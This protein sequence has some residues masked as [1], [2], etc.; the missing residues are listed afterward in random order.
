MYTHEQRTYSK[1]RTSLLKLMSTLIAVALTAS[2]LPTTTFASAITTDP[3][4]WNVEALTEAKNAERKAR[5]E[6]DVDEKYDLNILLI[7]CSYGSDTITYTVHFLK[8]LYPNLKINIGRLFRGTTPIKD[9]YE[10]SQSGADAYAYIEHYYNGNGGG[11]SRSTLFSLSTSPAYPCNM[12]TALDRA[13][14]DIVILQTTAGYCA[15][16][17]SYTDSTTNENYVSALLNYVD[18]YLKTKNS[19]SS[20]EFAWNMVWPYPSYSKASSF[21]DFE[22]NQLKMY[23]GILH[24]VQ[25]DVVKA[26]SE[27]DYIIP[28]GTA[29]VNA[30][31]NG[32]PD[33]VIYR[34]DIHL[35][36]QTNNMVG[37]G[38]WTTGLTTA[39]ALALQ[40]D[41]IKALDSTYSITSSDKAEKIVSAVG[42][43]STDVTDRTVSDYESLITDASKQAL[44]APFMSISSAARLI[45]QATY[46]FHT[47]ELTSVTEAQ[48]KAKLA[49]KVNAAED[50]CYTG[51][52]VEADDITVYDYDY[53]LSGDQ[54]F[55]FTV[56]Y[57]NGV[58]SE[59]LN[60][61]STSA[62]E[63]TVS[64]DFE[65]G[66]TIPAVSTLNFRFNRP[67]TSDT[68]IPANII[69]KEE[70]K[71]TAN[72]NERIYSDYE[73]KD[74]VYTINF[75]EGDLA[76]NTKYTL[77]FTTDIKTEDDLTLPE[78]QTFTFTTTAS[79]GW[80]INDNF[81][82]YPLNSEIPAISTKIDTNLLPLQYAISNYVHDT[83]LAA[84]V[85]ENGRKA[86]KVSAYYKSDSAP[87]SQFSVGYR[88]DYIPNVTQTKIKKCEV[89]FDFYGDDSAVYGIYTNFFTIARLADGKYY[90]CV[91]NAGFGTNI[92]ETTKTHYYKNK[93]SPLCEISEATSSSSSPHK[94]SFLMY[95]DYKTSSTTRRI[96]DVYLDGKKI[97]KMVDSNGVTASGATYISVPESGIGLSDG[98]Q[99][100][101]G[102][103]DI[104]Y[105]ETSG[106]TMKGNQ[107]FTSWVDATKTGEDAKE[108]NLRIYSFKYGECPSVSSNIE[109]FALDVYC[110][111]EVLLNF[112]I[113]LHA[114]SND[115]ESSITVTATEN[116]SAVDF[117]VDKLDSKTLKLQFR[118]NVY[119]D[120]R[121]D[122]SS[123]LAANSLPLDTFSLT[124]KTEPLGFIHSGSESSFDTEKCELNIKETFQLFNRRTTNG[125][126]YKLI[127]AVYNGD[128]LIYTKVMNA[129]TASSAEVA[130]LTVNE[131]LTSDD[132]T[133][134]DTFTYKAFVF[135][136]LNTLVP[137][138]LNK[139]GAI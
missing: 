57:E 31:G 66:V 71:G 11:V 102:V 61:R 4:N 79:D 134:D 28:N 47:D 75:A 98:W 40:S 70:V 133:S 62:T 114:S 130:E 118:K 94:L 68:A 87:A 92:A 125:I 76:A 46:R 55:S 137:L 60:A 51:V 127:F 110:D 19:S 65:N 123:L 97:T 96:Y 88:T 86:L 104:L 78:E 107:M 6:L 115:Y 41:K 45:E 32:I 56:T 84:I 52:T 33:A 117:T 16:D 95:S 126:N 73:Y 124:F 38:L 109:P 85:S 129:T 83:N 12:Q 77:T 39:C 27:I 48:L 91:R 139:L 103:H 131:A 13:D 58:T 26:V 50:V 24:N 74:G 111:R 36:D 20:P 8:A 22:N 128:K 15:V 113:P 23:N 9:H 43:A 121:I 25:K 53:A 63:L 17:G 49:E 132:F 119:M 69:L 100:T 59:R 116:D 101:A 64:A 90:L 2:L 105:K 138:T 37:A 122:V 93:L 18:N 67:A 82:R 99:D 29:V 35:S 3:Y 89:E 72:Y 135:D 112:A 7:G 54:L 42:K 10:L 34:D 14:W 5:M 1:M 120:Y 108:A 30:L 21:A 136:N 44:S 106:N 81:S 80:Y